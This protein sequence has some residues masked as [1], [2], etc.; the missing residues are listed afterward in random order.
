MYRMG[1]DGRLIEPGNR[2]R[3]LEQ[4][5]TFG[6]ARPDWLKVPEGTGSSIAHSASSNGVYRVLAGKTVTGVAATAADD[7]L[8]KAAHGLTDGT[9]VTVTT[10]VGGL[11]VGAAYY[12]R[13]ATTDTFKLSGSSGGAV[14]NITADGTVSIDATQVGNAAQLSTMDIYPARYSA[15]MFELLGLTIGGPSDVDLAVDMFFQMR[16]TS[17][18]PS[19]FDFHQRAVSP[20]EANLVS[21][22]A[23][24]TAPK[25]VRYTLRTQAEA[26]KRR[27]IGML[28]LIEDQQIVFF[29]GR[30]E[31]ERASRVHASLSTASPVVPR[32]R[33]VTQE[34]VAR[35]F[36]VSGVRLTLWER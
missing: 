30:P 9:R 28:W 35:S 2:K 24:V 34:A 18:T 10:A 14:V 13:D 16:S 26:Y 23:G 8:T 15:I 33:M 3:P 20:A 11:T 19:G 17:G 5:F 29:E 12:V 4:W 22:I 36:S 1:L 21:E 6:E 27:D 7:L 31:S 32:F 25:Q